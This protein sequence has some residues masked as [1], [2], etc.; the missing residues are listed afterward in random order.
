MQAQ[1]D[2]VHLFHLQAAQVG[3]HPGP[4]LLGPLGRGPPTLLV[5]LRTDLA[6]QHEVLGVGEK[7]C[8][9]QLVGHVGAVV[10]G[11]VDVVDTQ[12]DHPAEHGQSRGP[13]ARRAEHPR[14]GQLHGPE[15]DAAYGATS[16]FTGA[17]G[18]VEFLFARGNL[19]GHVVHPCPAPAL[20]VWYPTFLWAGLLR[21]F[22][23][24]WGSSSRFNL[25][26]LLCAGCRGL[27]PRGRP[28]LRCR[29]STRWRRW[30]GHQRRPL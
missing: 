9:D 17:A 22:A 24:S 26:R 27:W 10:L 23:C 29:R 15:A 25:A 4:K 2:N 14:P 13:V 20:V 8:V 3:L 21:V 19:V 28:Q 5:S 18:A 30:R 11:R 12:I 16:K 1:V 6:H 7:R